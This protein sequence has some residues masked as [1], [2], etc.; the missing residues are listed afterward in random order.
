MEILSTGEKI[1]RARIYKGLTLKDLCEEK[2]S[3]S[4][5]SCIENGKIKPE[6][7]ILDFIAEKLQVDP[8]YLKQDIRTQ[9]VRNVDELKKQHYSKEY[10]EILEYNL[11]YIE[12]YCYYDLSFEVIHL[13]FNYYLDQNKIEKIHLMI[14]KYYDYLQKCF[15]EDRSAIYYMDIARF[16]F[17]TKEFSQAASYY[18][19]V[20]KISKSRDNYGLLS[21]STY[22]EAACYLMLEDY[23]KAYEIAVRLIDLMDYIETDIKKAEAYHMLAML[24]LRRNRDKFSEYEQKSYELYKSDQVHKAQAIYNYAAVMFSVGLRDKAINY[25]NRALNCYPRNNKELLVGFMLTNINK[26][27][28]NDV[29]EKAQGICD[30][31]LNYAIALDNIIFVERA[32]YYKALILEREGNLNSAEM[33]MNLSLDAL[34]K[35]ASN[36]QIYKRYMEMGDMYHRM[37]NINESI[38]YFNFAI[39]LEKKM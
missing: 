11:K 27:I 21:R 1:K 22:N 36:S 8:D 19:N 14:S 18:N 24:C 39:Q 34:L 28:E 3:V 20:R 16:L 35:F 32:Y 7:W 9:L 30:E 10:E 25:V 31:A 26:L 37:E 33:Y 4:K 5:M 17:S 29:L 13:L 38:K 12:E 2:I 23:D 6:E 15:T